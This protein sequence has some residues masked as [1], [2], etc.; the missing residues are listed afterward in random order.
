MKKVTWENLTIDVDIIDYHMAFAEWKS[1]LEG[2][3]SP[4]MVTK[5]GDM[6]FQREDGKVY[7]LDTNDGGIEDIGLLYDAFGSFINRPEVIELYLYSNLV[8]DLI[9][10]DM[11]LSG[12]QSYMFSIPLMLGG[13]ECKDNVIVMDL[14]LGNSLK[15]QMFN[16][17][18]D[19]PEG[20]QIT[21]FK[22]AERK[23][24]HE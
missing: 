20:Y 23:T 18:K 3:F 9:N 6:F 24:D 10:N 21:G 12:N 15:G 7:F 13:K 4:I 14:V 8:F 11:E 5:F 22:Y 16:Q 1:F 19:K 17:L 2:K